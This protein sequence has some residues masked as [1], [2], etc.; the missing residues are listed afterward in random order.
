M[1][2]QPS[3][4]RNAIA[5]IAMQAINYFVPLITLPYL[6]RTLGVEQ[7]GALNLALSIIQ[8]AIL[9]TNFGFNLSTTQYIAV[10]RGRPL[11]V[12]RAFWE[13]LTAKSLLMLIAFIALSIVTLNVPSFYEIRWIIAILFLQVVAAAFDPIWFFQGIE[14]LSRISLINSAI[15][16]LSI[17][18]LIIFVRSP[19]DLKMAAFIQAL[20]TLLVMGSNLFFS[21]KEKVIKLIKPSQLKIKMAIQLSLP[22]FIGTAAISLYNTATPI[23]LGIVS[24]YEEVGIYSASFRIRGALLGVFLVLGQVFYP[25]VNSLFAKDHAL[26][27]NFVKKLMLWLLPINITATLSLYFIIPL[28]APWILGEGF[29]ETAETLKIMAPMMILVPYAVIFSNY[30]LLPLGYKR[31]FYI[32]PII[33]GTLHL[34]YSIYLSK[35]Y[36]AIG[37]SWSITITEIFSCGILAFLAF[38]KT[39]IKKYLKLYE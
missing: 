23:I 10:N 4:K 13:T 16:F 17:P 2:N 18:L 34:S 30:L 28:L 27:Y 24:N 39:D 25:R 8:Y 26:G 11:L 3:L 22:L 20:I 7:Y 21:Y 31:L 14:K 29:D 5:L 6:T 12:S 36:G 37:A 15:R 33:T 38:R 19:D 9:L 1:S 32:V 35:H